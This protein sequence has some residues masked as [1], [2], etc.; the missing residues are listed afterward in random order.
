MQRN[1][2]VM[3][4]MLMYIGMVSLSEAVMMN[5]GSTCSKGFVYLSIPADLVTANKDAIDVVQS[6]N[7]AAVTT[8][9]VKVLANKEIVINV[10]LNSIDDSADGLAVTVNTNLKPTYVRRNEKQPLVLYFND[11]A[12]CVLFENECLSECSRLP[13]VVTIFFT[14]FGFLKPDALISID[15][16][17]AV[18][19][20][21]TSLLMSTENCTYYNSFKIRIN[22]VF[23]SF[24]DLMRE[25]GLLSTDIFHSSSTSA[26]TTTAATTAI[27]RIPTKQRF[28]L[29]NHSSWVWSL[30]V[31]ENGDLVSGSEDKTIKL[32]NPI[33]GSLKKTINGH[34]GAVGTLV[35]H[36]NGSFISSSTDKTIKIWTND[37]RLLQTLTEH[38]G[39]VWGLAVFKNG[40]FA[41]G[42]YDKTIK[43][44]SIDGKL[45]NTL[46]GH[47]HAIRR[48]AVHRNGDLVSVSED[49]SIR[50]WTSEGTL[51]HTL[52]GHKNSV[53][54]LAILQSGDIVSGSADNTVKVWN[55]YGQLKNTFTYHE[56]YVSSVAVLPNGDIASGAYD[57][58]II[59]SDVNGKVKSVIEAHNKDN[60]LWSLVVLPNG[61]LVSASWDKTVK[62]WTS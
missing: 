58:R 18:T 33:D 10:K 51:K 43:I 31:L 14:R 54:G 20:N 40:D 61:D 41:S 15:K 57:G 8:F 29:S 47:T 48:L 37:G 7:D 32:W 49:A 27:Y 9:S 46:V 17:A 52:L 28:T 3:V 50:I 55:E 16:S 2:A 24:Y 6:E 45:K 35:A 22:S 26:P 38:T 34:T 4:M 12:V 1:I 11:T 36:R 25:Y 60:Y 42:S 39:E 30:C 23:K 53:H 21:R 59:I 44:W 19:N 5:C 62:I 13:S 56:H